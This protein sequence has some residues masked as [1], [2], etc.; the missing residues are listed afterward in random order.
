MRTVWKYTIGPSGGLVIPN[1]LAPTV[2]HFGHDPAS[3]QHAV[4]IEH[5]TENPPKIIFTPE[6]L[7]LVVYGTGQ[8]IARGPVHIQSIVDGPF[9]WHLYGQLSW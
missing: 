8:E 6:T 7:S 3:G 2:A 4:W 9:V 1:L 5:Y